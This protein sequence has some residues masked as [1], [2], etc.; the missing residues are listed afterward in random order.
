MVQLLFNLYRKTT[1]TSLHSYSKWRIAVPITVTLLLLFVSHSGFTQ[2]MNLE[3]CIDYAFSH[4]LSISNTQLNVEM[5]KENYQQSKRDLLPSIEASTSASMRFGKSIDP[6]TNDFFNQRFFS[7]DM[8]ISSNVTLF[9]GFVKQNNIRYAQYNYLSQIESYKEQK[10][11]VQFQIMSAFYQVVFNKKMVEVLKN[12][13]E[14]SEL[15]LTKTKKMVDLGLKAQSDVL[16]M[17]SQLAREVHEKIQLENAFELSKLTLKNRMNYPLEKTL[18]LDDEIVEASLSQLP[19][20]DIY[21]EVEKNYPAYQQAVLAL[22]SAVKKIDIQRGRLYPT[23]SLGGGYATNFSDS[24]KEKVNDKLRV[25]PFSNQIKNNAAQ[26]IYLSLRIPIF[27]QWDYRSRIKQA[28]LER[29]VAENKVKE[30]KQLMYKQVMED[31][32]IMKA[33][34][35]EITQLEIQQSALE[36]TYQIGEKKLEKGLINTLELYTMKNQLAKSQADLFRAQLQLKIKEKTIR[37]YLGE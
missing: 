33:L 15:N 17:E 30:A 24:R 9:N 13:I 12:Q 23:L 32:Q 25:V 37:I 14:L 27:Y 16:E 19:L 1:N 34:Q 18:T 21:Q 29:K 31:Y 36:V 26:N 28:K 35:K 10:M 8:Y 3:N 11:N 7:T 2:T 20:D 4:N 22:K 5:A 6:T